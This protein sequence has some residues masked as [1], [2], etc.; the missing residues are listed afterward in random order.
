M[1]VYT[2]RVPPL[3]SQRC[4]LL[5]SNSILCFSFILC[6]HSTI[7][8]TPILRSKSVP[9][10]VLI[11]AIIMN[12]RKN[13][14]RSVVAGSLS[15]EVKEGKRKES[16]SSSA[17]RSKKAKVV[18]V[19][20]TKA[21]KAKKGTPKKKKK[22][23]EEAV[24]PVVPLGRTSEG[25]ALTAEPALAT[26]S[27]TATVAADTSIVGGKSVAPPISP[28]AE[29]LDSGTKSTTEPADEVVPPVVPLRGTSEGTALTAE[30]ALATG[31][32]TATVAADTSIVGGKSIA[33]PISPTAEELDSGTK[34]T[35]EPAEEV[36][37]P[38]DPVDAYI[39]FDGWVPVSLERDIDLETEVEMEWESHAICPHS[40][41]RSLLKVVAMMAAQPSRNH[42]AMSVLKTKNV[43]S[44]QMRKRQR[45]S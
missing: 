32:P 42:S 2:V 27:P 26:G 7:Q 11:K 17:D 21:K 10:S 19:P 23:E 8:I 40:R 37:P 9:V 15:P 30:P 3:K 6:F 13:S 31:S 4:S 43:L 24:P 38:V 16:G 29:E 33:P 34:S 14:T 36:V 44:S 45:I 1:P 25:T 41:S 22:A 12:T 5:I 18:V 28:T 20:P 39:P 35:T